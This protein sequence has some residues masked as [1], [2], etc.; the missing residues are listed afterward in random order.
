MRHVLDTC[1][2]CRATFHYQSFTSNFRARNQE[3]FIDTRWIDLDDLK[4]WLHAKQLSFYLVED[5]SA[6]S[7][8]WVA[9]SFQKLFI[10]DHGASGPPASHHS[11]TN[12]LRVG[13]QIPVFFPKIPP[14][15]IFPLI[16]FGRDLLHH[17]Q[18]TVTPDLRICT[19]PNFHFRY[20]VLRARKD[21]ACASRERQDSRTEIS[22]CDP[23]C[24]AKGDFFFVFLATF[25]MIFR[26]VHPAWFV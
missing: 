17:H 2:A 26:L 4:S 12:L 8:M 23:C 14:T 22:T 16:P 7:L 15:T 21:Q 13:S 3:L 1:L 19:H 18:A 10:I 9:C 20:Q 6:G 25:L 11:S 24:G 5:Q